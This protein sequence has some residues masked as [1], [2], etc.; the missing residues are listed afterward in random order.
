MEIGLLIFY[1]NVQNDQTFFMKLFDKDDFISFKF[2]VIWLSVFVE[3]RFKNFHAISQIT[4]R[5]EGMN[6]H[7][8]E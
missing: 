1:E 5:S 6:D 7:C 8:F 4:Y 2:K 3:I